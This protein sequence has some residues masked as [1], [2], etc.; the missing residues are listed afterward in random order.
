MT[1]GGSS[2]DRWPSLTSGICFIVI[3]NF[4]SCQLSLCYVIFD[5]C[6][7]IYY[8]SGLTSMSHDEVQQYILLETVLK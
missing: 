1:L 7:Q 2:P 8:G 6:G 3:F 5:Y 4:I